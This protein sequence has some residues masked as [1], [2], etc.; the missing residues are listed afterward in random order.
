MDV[1]GSLLVLAGAVTF[2][3][4]GLGLLRFP[5]VYTRTSAVATAAG[6]GLVLIVG[7]AVVMEPSVSNAWK[8]VLLIA[9][10][11]VTSAVGSM[12]I[13]RSAYLVGVPLARS[14]FDDLADAEAAVEAVEVTADDD[15]DG[16]GER[17]RQDSNL[18]PTD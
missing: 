2:A 16:G 7:G 9:L 17:P 4:A 12:A 11:L 3:T 18:R 6:V 15:D 5:D 8:A 1:V 10:Q 14:D 13:A